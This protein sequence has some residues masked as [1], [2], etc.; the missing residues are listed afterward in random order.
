VSDEVLG[1]APGPEK[2]ETLLNAMEET[3]EWRYI[4]VENSPLYRRRERQHTAFRARILR[5]F[6]E[7]ETYHGFYIGDEE[8][9]ETMHDKD[10][11]I[12]QLEDKV[13]YLRRELE[14][15][16]RVWERE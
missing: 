6:E 12:K 1:I 14:E 4:I 7:W 11:R 13:H 16:K 9:I 5:M 10:M 3:K 15:R 2:I 8:F